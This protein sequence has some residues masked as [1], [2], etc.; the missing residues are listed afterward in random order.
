MDTVSYYLRIKDYINFFIRPII[1]QILYIY[2][3]FVDLILSKY[4]L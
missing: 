1:S 4:D 2:L 3:S